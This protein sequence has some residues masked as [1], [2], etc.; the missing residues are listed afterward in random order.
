MALLDPPE[1]VATAEID[2]FGPITLVPG[3]WHDLLGNDSQRLCFVVT[4]VPA[5]DN[6][7]VWPAALTGL[8]GVK[9]PAFQSQ[10][11]IHYSSYPALCQGPWVIRSDVGAT[12]A[13][14]YAV[15]RH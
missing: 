14:G 11:L 1:I 7:F 4:T 10:V 2:A 13:Y 3:Q 12:V 9:P 8:G 15:R 6:F 5:T